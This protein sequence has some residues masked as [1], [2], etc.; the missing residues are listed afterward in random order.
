MSLILPELAKHKNDQPACTARPHHLR[1]GHRISISRCSIPR[2]PSLRALGRGGDTCGGRWQNGRRNDE[3]PPPLCEQLGLTGP[4]RWLHRPAPTP[5]HSSPAERRRGG[6][7]GG[8]T[9]MSDRSGLGPHTLHSL[10]PHALF[11]ADEQLLI[12][13]RPPARHPRLG[14]SPSLCSPL[15]HLDLTAPHR[16]GP[17]NRPCL[18]RP[19]SLFL[20]SLELSRSRVAGTGRRGWT[21]PLEGGSANRPASLAGAPPVR[22]TLLRP[23][24]DLFSGP[25]HPRPPLPLAQAPLNAATSISPS[26]SCRMFRDISGLPGAVNAARGC[27]RPRSASLGRFTCARACLPVAPDETTIKGPADRNRRPARDETNMTDGSAPLGTTS[28]GDEEATCILLLEPVS[29]VTCWVASAE[30]RLR[31]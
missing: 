23:P 8:A 3:Q 19:S 31:Q 22:A 11:E 27:C 2:L 15:T 18:S 6:G 28:A 24:S 5:V 4:L 14:L 25:L 26:M 20:A 16:H 17:A 12:R 13:P 30:C 7:G 1:N 10:L 29:G 9:M 21:L